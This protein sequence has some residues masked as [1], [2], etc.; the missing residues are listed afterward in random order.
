MPKNT[1]RLSI[2]D[3]DE[4]QELFGLP[5]LSDDERDFY[6]SLDQ[7]EHQILASLRNVNSKILFLLQLGYFKASHQ[8]FVFSFQEVSSDL[9]YIVRRYFSQEKIPKTVPSKNTRLSQ[10]KMILRSKNYRSFGTKE[11]QL[12]YDKAKQ[13]SK[14]HAQF[15]FLLTELLRILDAEQIILPGYS[16]FQKIIG[17]VTQGEQ[18]RLQA[19]L[20]EQVPQSVKV[21]L[22][23]LLTTDGSF[24]Q[25]T[26]LKKRAKD[27]K[28]KQIRQEIRK[29]LDIGQLYE[30][31]RTFLP[32][33]EISNENVK[34]YASLAEYYPIHRLKNMPENQAQLYLLCFIFHCF[35]KISDNLITSF[36]HQVNTT[37]QEARQSSQKKLTEYNLEHRQQLQ[38]T[39]KIIK[40][41]VDESIDDQ[42]PFKEIKQR[43]FKIIDEEEIKE[44]VLYLVGKKINPIYYEWS[45]IEQVSRKIA[46]N[47]RPLF[48]VIEFK[49]TL[50]NDPIIEA[51]KRLKDIYQSEKSLVFPLHECFNKIIPKNVKPW[52]TH[53]SH[54][55]FFIYEQLKK[56]L[57]AGDI[58]YS[59]STLYKSFD[60]DL[61][62]KEELEEKK[63][64]LESLDFPLLNTPMA[65]RLVDLKLVLEQRYKEVNCNILQGKN[66]HLKF[67]QKNDEIRW[68]LPYKKQEDII[69]NPFYG[70]LPQIGVI[71]IL[72]YVNDQCSFMEAF[73]HIQPRYAKNA[74]EWTNV[75]ACIISYGERIG[76]S[77]MADISDT[78][79]HLLR[80][81]SK[82]Y[83]H[84][85]NIRKANDIIVNAITK[86]H[87]F[88]Y[89]NMDIGTL[90]ASADG[91]KF[92]AQRATFKAR[93]SK[94][95][96]GLNKGLV[97]YSL[98]VNHVPANAKLIGANE[99]ESHYAF[100]IIF[101]NTSEIDPNIISVDMA[102]T[103][104]V[105]FALLETFG[106]I[107][108]PRYTRINRKATKLVSFNPTDH[109]PSEYL[110]KPSRQINEELILNETEN[111]QR[112]FASLALKTTTQS[113]IVKK[114]SAYARRNRTKKALWELDNIY[115][116]LYILEY[117]D[118][119]TLRRNVQRA[120]NRGEA[121]HQLQRAIT[122]PN[123][124]KF[125]G[126]TEYE[127]TIESDC[128]RLIANAIIFYN[129]AMLS[130][131][132]IRLE[133]EDK[134]EGIELVKRLSPVAWRHINLFGRYE[135]NGV[136][137]MP[138]LDEM[139]D[140]IR[141]N[142]G[143]L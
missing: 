11:Y 20:Q 77:T 23:N 111:L 29:Y 35:E 135:F 98:V 55:E 73:E 66:S 27:F 101:N 117:I 21:A 31:S 87:I 130:K 33:L 79:N 43:A 119:L 64:L 44:V 18:K 120:L 143:S 78:K 126:T 17:L 142:F 122:H 133:L 6:F 99:H 57:D 49:S 121:Y 13:L 2:L 15:R 19:C 96:F 28:L 93:Y 109:Y 112:I 103:N 128:S 118:N 129:T 54:C 94:K 132:L 72:Q 47:I 136:L 48:M 38:K 138:D 108:A 82:N 63:H 75:M 124:G 113:T 114:L 88:K 134:E 50:K 3:P 56:G 51:A 59:N 46:L 30:F 65:K 36:I 34:Y 71:N 61:S 141:L 95:Y 4:V 105:N 8:F 1:K 9:H 115:R 68:T 102:G 39:G 25:L 137:S 24:Y 86:L 104:Q 52:I 16:T 32:K 69:N 131:L 125:R 140:N 10:Q 83:M 89:Y 22:N 85:E 106:R 40:F 14:I 76:L 60:E 81:T 123:G 26:A 53:P 100:D 92:E 45:Y 7:D 12:L 107:W 62:T 74:A 70:Q 116:S 37:S 67:S 90:H 41:F 97:N 80:T 127:I 139:I 110:I 84:P 91:Q 5:C 58:F 42:T